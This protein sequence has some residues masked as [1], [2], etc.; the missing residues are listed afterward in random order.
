MLGVMWSRSGFG[1]VLNRDNGKCA[2]A[3]AFDAA[4]IEIDVSNFNLRRK[5]V[6]LHGKSVV[7]RSDFHMAIAEVLNGLITAAMS[8]DKFE[9]LTAKSASQQLM[10]EANTEGGQA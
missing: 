7:V 2:M 3:K 8:K 9:S 6:G 4:I 1:M 5:A 10:A